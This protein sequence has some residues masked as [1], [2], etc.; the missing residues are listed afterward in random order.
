MLTMSPAPLAT[1]V[2]RAGA[3]F[4]V[5]FAVTAAPAAAEPFDAADLSAG[6]RAVIQT[7]LETE[8]TNVRNRLPD[9]GAVFTILR[10]ATSPRIC[11]WFSLRR[12]G[13]V[14]TGVGCRMAEAAW[15]LAGVESLD[16]ARGGMARA[17]EAPPAPEPAAPDPSPD[18]SARSEGSPTDTATASAPPGWVADPPAPP[19]PPGAVPA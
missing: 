15:D 16:T 12:E 3:A 5:V 10:T 4:A 13:A 18:Q 7:L 19:P 17:S 8:R 6:D 2:R 9:S 1:V 14:E 11:R